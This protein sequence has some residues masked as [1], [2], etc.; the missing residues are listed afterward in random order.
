ML[1]EILIKSSLISVHE[2]KKDLD[3]SKLINESISLQ[4]KPNSQQ[5]RGIDSTV[6]VAIISAASTAFGALIA[7]LLKIAQEHNHNKIVIVGKFG[8]K[9]E[10]PANT[11]PEM[12]NK[13]VEIA[14]QLDSNLIEL[15]KD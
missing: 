7:G 5:I 3:K 6:L 11:K 14:E 2:I 8:R 13:F 4:I 12:L 10:I 9:I 1:N 15:K